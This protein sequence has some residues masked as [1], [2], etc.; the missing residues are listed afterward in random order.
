MS[1]KIVT[2]DVREDIRQ[3]REPFGRIMQTVSKLK[4]DEDLLLIAPFEP[5]PLF[6]VL[7]QYGFSHTAT[8]LSSGDWQVLFERMEPTTLQAE[9]TVCSSEPACGCVQVI[10]VDAR[11]LDPPEPMVTIL[12]ALESLPSH[13]RL[14]ARTDRRPIHLYSHLEERGFVG[15]SQEQTDGTFITDIRRN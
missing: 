10:E 6:Q 13:A 4:A 11:G 1:Q 9:T 8:P 5:V 15:E 7:S 2:L 12:E 3:G 14:R